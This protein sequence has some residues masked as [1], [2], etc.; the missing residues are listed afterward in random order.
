M[1]RTVVATVF[2]LLGVLF[3]SAPQPVRAF[4]DAPPVAPEHAM[5][6]GD[7][8]AGACVVDGRTEDTD[9]GDEAAT[10]ASYGGPLPLA[11]AIGRHAAPERRLSWSCTERRLTSCQG[12]P[13]LPPPRLRA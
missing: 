12:R 9:D 7:T 5:I 11:A 13:L 8:T 6:A 4:A 2:V 10:H 1:L 3:L